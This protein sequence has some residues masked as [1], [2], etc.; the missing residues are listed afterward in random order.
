LVNIKKSYSPQKGKEE[1][2]C[3]KVPPQSDIENEPPRVIIIPGS[4]NTQLVIY[5]RKK[6]KIGR[7]N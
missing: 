4:L 5:H 6:S 3:G 1:P 7:K 2:A